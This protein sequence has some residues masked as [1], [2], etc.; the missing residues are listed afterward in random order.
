M[1]AGALEKARETGTL[2]N[3]A[4]IDAG[5]NLKA[6]RRMDEAWLGS[7]DAAI[8]EAR[9]AWYFDMPTGAWVPSPSPAGRCTTSRCPTAD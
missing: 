7:I 9:T 5:G 8:N 6:F 1:L 2:M 3:I 4:V